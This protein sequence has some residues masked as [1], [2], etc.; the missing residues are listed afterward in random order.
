MIGIIAALPQEAATLGIKVK[1]RKRI[2]NLSESILLLVS[3]MGKQNA[4]A[5]ARMLAPKVS[6][7]ISWGTAAGLVKDL[8]AGALIVPNLIRD[9]KG[10][11]IST[12]QDFIHRLEKELGT[13]LHMHKG[14]LA[15]SPEIL[16]DPKQKKNFHLATQ[17]MAADMESAA[18]ASIA[19]KVQIPF[20]A[21]R[22]IMDDHEM[23]IP[24][25]ILQA[26]TV[27]GDMDILRLLSLLCFHPSQWKKVFLLSV[28]F[29]SARSTLGKAGKALLSL[30]S[31]R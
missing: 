23:V 27:N 29:N 26:R 5:A 30:V 24:K 9:Q 2:V 14:L 10:H 16:S 25:V 20:N 22:A 28:S 17:A 13:G 6:C 11:S 3:G 31:D 12:D 8:N 1:A 15:E 18:I 21:I 4:E 7:L 19:Q